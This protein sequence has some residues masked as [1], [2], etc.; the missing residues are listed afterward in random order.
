MV[1]VKKKDVICL[2][3]RNGEGTVSRWRGGG[4]SNLFDKIKVC[5]VPTLVY[6]LGELLGNPSKEERG[7]LKMEVVG[8]GRGGM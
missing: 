2:L 4:D 5:E 7:I 3:Q 8:L 6:Y 1:V